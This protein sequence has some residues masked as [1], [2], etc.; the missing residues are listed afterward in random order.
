[1]FGKDSGKY[2]YFRCSLE[3]CT[4]QGNK[5]LILKVSGSIK[6]EQEEAKGEIE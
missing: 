5:T 6:A 2:V 3:L 1:L 4:E